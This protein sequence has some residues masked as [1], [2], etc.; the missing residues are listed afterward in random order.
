MK[1]Q[2]RTRIPCAHSSKPACQT[3]QG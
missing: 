2:L 3:K 1:F